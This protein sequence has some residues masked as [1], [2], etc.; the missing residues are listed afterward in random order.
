MAFHF[1]YYAIEYQE[2]DPTTTTEE[3]PVV[4]R[5]IRTLNITD[6]LMRLYFDN[7]NEWKKRG[8]F[9][10]LKVLKDYDY[11][12]I[13]TLPAERIMNDYLKNFGITIVGTANK[14][15]SKSD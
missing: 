3:V 8:E 6:P 7:S 15:P 14:T 10:N 11:A 5:L 4:R 9:Y 13:G 2:I 12:A 1:H